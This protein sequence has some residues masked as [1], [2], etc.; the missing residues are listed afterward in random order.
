M[1]VE[2]VDG[3]ALQTFERRFD[4]LLDVVGTAIARS[5]FAAVI[6]ICFK[7]ELGGDDYFLRNGARAAPTISSLT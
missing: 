2:E 6:R 1:L 4:D 7:S 3:V 5:P